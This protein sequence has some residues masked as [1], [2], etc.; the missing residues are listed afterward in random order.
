M[1][2]KIEK[3]EIKDDKTLL[4]RIVELKQAGIQV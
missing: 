3:Q 2:K 4:G 1:L